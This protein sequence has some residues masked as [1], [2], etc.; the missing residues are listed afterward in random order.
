MWLC[1]RTREGQHRDSW[2]QRGVCPSD[3]EREVVMGT[4]GREEREEGGDGAVTIQIVNTAMAQWQAE[5]L[6]YAT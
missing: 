1:N 3:L 5:V 4:E 2:S 6:F